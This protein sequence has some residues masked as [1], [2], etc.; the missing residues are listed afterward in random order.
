MVADEVLDGISVAA[1]SDRWR[2]RLEAGLGAAERV[3]LAE[4]DGGV[5]GF[6]STGPSRDE[7]ADPT[8]HEI[9]AM[10]VDP[11][12]VGRGIGAALMREAL[13]SMADRGA[14][15]ITLWVLEANSRARQFYER[16][17]FAADGGATF[18]ERLKAREL[19]YRRV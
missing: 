3:L 19:R 18:D 2:G 12:L 11:K 4:V 5:R 8:V 7:D 16:F 6:V 14:K 10:Y 9:Q 1:R 15:S 17:G 13:G